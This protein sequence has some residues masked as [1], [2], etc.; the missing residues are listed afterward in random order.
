MNNYHLKMLEV[1]KT[2]EGKPKLLLH[3]CCA[4]CTSA[5]LEILVN[6]FEVTIYYFNP[7]MNDNEEY[8]RRYNE[9]AKLLKGLNLEN[10]EVIKPDYNPEAFYAFAH[11]YALEKEGGERCHLCY[12]YRLQETMKYAASN[13][14]D[15]V[16]TTLTVSPYKDAQLLNEI[17]LSLEQ[18]YRVKYLPSDFKKNEGYKR[19]IELSKKFSLYR[20]NYCGCVYSKIKLN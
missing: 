5:C 7:N 20:Q 11:Q 16:T 1:L 9:F 6:Y 2:L 13:N 4:P 3:A 19:S 10:I 8:E 14:F 18:E 15:Y 12:R 17:G